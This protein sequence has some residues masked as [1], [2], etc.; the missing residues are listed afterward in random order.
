MRARAVSDLFRTV[1]RQ[2][3]V[4][5]FVYFNTRGSRDWIIDQDPKALAVFRSHADR[6]GFGFTVA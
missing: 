3:D 4:I 1:G 5:G 2:K 6:V